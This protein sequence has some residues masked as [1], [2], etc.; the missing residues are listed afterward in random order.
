MKTNKYI[1]FVAIVLSALS[2]CTSCA[3]KLEA[4]SGDDVTIEMTINRVSAGFI[5]V[6]F[7]PDELA[8][9]LVTVDKA[10]PGIKLDDCEQQFMDLS[11]DSAYV[12]YVE[13]RHDHLLNLEE[14]VADFPSHSLYYG[15]TTMIK[16]FLEPNTDYWV[17]AFV[18]DKKSNKANGRLFYKTIHTKSRSIYNSIRFAYR[19]K[20]EWDYIYPYNMNSGELVTDVP[21]IGKTADSLE[22]HRLGFRSPGQYF[23]SEFEKYEEGVGTI[24][25]GIY[26]HQ[27]NGVGDGTSTTKFEKGHTYY[28]AMAVLDGPRNDCFD[29]YR[30]T[31]TGSED[32]VILSDEHNTLGAW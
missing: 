23:D 18:V 20:G 25:T 10:I 17:C 21:W 8:Y 13:W 28:T 30:F 27:N 14:H 19:V 26:A 15:T 2:L 5:D 29:I 1:T 16:N 24:F 6:T 4:V 9:Y 7:A 11:L 22:I 31:W 32:E 3:L 12:K